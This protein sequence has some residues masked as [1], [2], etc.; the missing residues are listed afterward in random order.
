M[1]CVFVLEFLNSQA[2]VSE[3][4]FVYKENFLRVNTNVLIEVGNFFAEGDYSFS[5]CH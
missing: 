5:L 3:L 1:N 2:K 4:F